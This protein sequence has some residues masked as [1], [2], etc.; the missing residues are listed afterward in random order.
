MI[1]K[2]HL[3]ARVPNEGARRLAW[4]LATHAAPHRV[5]FTSKVVPSV[6]GAAALLAARAKLSEATIDR[7]LRG[8]LVPGEE[9]GREISVATAGVVSMRDW[10]DAARGGWS[11]RPAYGF[12][13]APVR[14]SP[15]RRRT[16]I[17]DPARGGSPTGS[18]VRALRQSGRCADV[19]A[20]A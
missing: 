20:R 7:L 5:P 10:R 1:F 11:D 6:A 12:G 13:P 4:W 2:M 19:E 14:L 3:I 15:G 8:E 16:V 9:Q 18:W 17:D